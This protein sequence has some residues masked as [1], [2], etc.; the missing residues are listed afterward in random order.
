MVLLEGMVD[1]H[2]DYSDK[3][4]WQTFSQNELNELIDSKKTT[5]ST[6]CQR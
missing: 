6:F 1:R 4:I 5:G 3:D 2:A